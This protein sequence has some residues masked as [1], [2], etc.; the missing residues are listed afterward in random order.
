MGPVRGHNAP[1]HTAVQFCAAADG[2]TL[3]WAAAG[4]GPPVLKVPGWLSDVGLDW[5]GSAWGHWYREL[6]RGRK[7]VT[8]DPRG[9]GWSSRTP[10]EISFER[11][12]AD[13]EA[14][15]AAAALGRFALFSSYLGAPL[16]I[17]FAARHPDRVS[18]LVLHGAA[19]VGPLSPAAGEAARAEAEAVARLIA[20]SWG[21]DPTV[22]DQFFTVQLMPDAGPEV[23][24][25]LRAHQQRAAAPEMAAQLFRACESA[26]VSAES[27]R[28]RCPVLVTHSTGDARIGTQAAHDLAALLRARFVE[29]A[30]RNHV[31]LETEP[32]WTRWCELLRGFLP[33]SEAEGGAAGARR[34]PKLSEREGQVLELLARG[35][36]NPG[37][38]ERLFVSEKTVRNYVSTLFAKLGVA[39]RAEAIV[40]ARTAGYGARQAEG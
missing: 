18:H 29:L 25:A 12:V 11:L 27:A 33:C 10:P 2:T 36:D 3:A 37:I 6:G 26:D 4:S 1:M 14:V 20:T 22:I 31:L 19:A 24:R 21:R 15:A 7:L 32:A 16:A 30:S 8:W 9:S 17:A 40:A 13:L 39:T 38:A 23:W 5:S 28:V 34:A 35:L